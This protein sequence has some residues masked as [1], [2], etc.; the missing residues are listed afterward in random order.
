M[1]RYV[2]DLDS[3][4]H[5]KYQRVPGIDDG[6]STQWQRVGLQWEEGLQALVKLRRP[7]RSGSANREK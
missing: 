6:E 4:T 7:L 1:S 3:R 2:T 5:G